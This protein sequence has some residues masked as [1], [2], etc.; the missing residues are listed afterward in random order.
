MKAKTLF[1]LYDNDKSNLL[2]LDELMV[3]MQNALSCLLKLDGRE[4]PSIVE[5]ADRT[6]AYFRATD[7]DNDQKINFNEFKTYLK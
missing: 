1:Q 6:R 3:L 7:A 2:S 5:V 4:P